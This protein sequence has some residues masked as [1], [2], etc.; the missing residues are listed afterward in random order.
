MERKQTSYAFL[1]EMLW[2]CGF[3]ILS[4]CIFV[5]VFVKA[6]QMSRHAEDLNQAVLIAENTIEDT[7]FQYA[8]GIEIP[9]TETYYFDHDSN[10]CADEAA[11]TVTSHTDAAFYVTVSSTV[12][13][14]LLKVSVRVDDLRGTAIYTL[15]GAHYEE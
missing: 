5:L 15:N 4:A 14:K 7:F 9:E 2:V 13:D 11:H 3:F 10:P 1:T 12:E 6:N 8:N